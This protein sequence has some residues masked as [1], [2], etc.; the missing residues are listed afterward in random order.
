[1]SGRYLLDTH[2]AI[3]MLGGDKAV[4]RRVRQSKEVYLC[5][6]VLGELYWGAFN[7]GKRDENVRKIDDLA[8][9]STVLAC[10]PNTAREYGLVKQRLRQK[11]RPIPENDIWIGAT[12]RQHSLT[13]VTRDA[14][15]SEIEGLATEA[16]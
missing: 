10:D 7:S 1:V 3:A 15:F 6:T 9:H 5:S 16:W 8:A 4:T 14:H 12:A 2:I 13:L 11:G